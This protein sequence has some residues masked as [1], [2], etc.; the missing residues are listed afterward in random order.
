[1]SISLGLR[2]ETGENE[3]L[4]AMHFLIFFSDIVK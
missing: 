4:L 3:T 1:M 2:I